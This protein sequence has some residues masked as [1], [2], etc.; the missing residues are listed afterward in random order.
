MKLII[1]VTAVGSFLNRSVDEHNRKECEVV[2]MT[3][4]VSK[5]RRPST[6]NRVIIIV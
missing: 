3:I 4:F 2:L 6:P 5:R 1:C